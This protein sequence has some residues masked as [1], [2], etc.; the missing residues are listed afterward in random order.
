MDRKEYFK[1]YYQTNKQTLFQKQK[2]RENLLR[3]AHDGLSIKTIRLKQS[4]DK[5][6]ARAD[7]F[8]EKLKSSV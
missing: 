6:N 4:I 3:K 1:K 7:Q 5:L 2:E 8:R